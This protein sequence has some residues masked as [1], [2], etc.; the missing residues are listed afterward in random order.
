MLRAF[1]TAVF[2]TTS[3]PVSALDAHNAVYR[4]DERSP[5]E[6]RKD[7]GIWPSTRQGSRLDDS[8]MNHYEGRSVR[9]GTS[10]FV[11][12]WNLPYAVTYG[13]AGLDTNFD[14]GESS[15][16][17]RL[18]FEDSRQFYL[19]EIR[20]GNEFFDV[21]QAFVNARELAPTE[22]ERRRFRS[23]DVPHSSLHYSQEVVARDGF[24]HRRIV[25]SA[26]LTGAMLNAYINHSSPNITEPS[27]WTTRWQDNDSY[28]RTFNGDTVSAHPYPLIE[29]PFGTRLVVHNATSTTTPAPL[30][31]SCLGVSF[32]HPSNTLSHRTEPLSASPAKC[33]DVRALN[34]TQKI[35]DPA[36][37]AL[38][39]D[40]FEN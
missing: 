30:S 1:A 33:P 7:G 24:G 3:I 9:N 20:P 31:A 19:Y 18:W 11:S 27:F 17:F 23:A 37:K 16:G 36:L 12:T 22:A 10:H 35:Y 21:R 40:A 28:E 26:V 15:D 14:S 38:A 8:L 5:A 13:I 6:I 39:L 29:R 4:L 34:I 25:R 32:G 2:L